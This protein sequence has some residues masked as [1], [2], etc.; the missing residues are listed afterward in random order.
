LRALKGAQRV[1]VLV[2]ARNQ[3]STVFCVVAPIVPELVAEELVDEGV[4][5]NGQSTDR[6]VEMAAASG[7]TVLPL[8]A[9]CERS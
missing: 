8:P 2:P 7:A 9:H 1:I 3:G 6:T 4:V 5:V